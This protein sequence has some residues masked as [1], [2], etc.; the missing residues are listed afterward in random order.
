MNE[1]HPSSSPILSQA[2]I[3][4]QPK[5]LLRPQIVAKNVAVSL[6]TTSDVVT[7][8]FAQR[9]DDRPVEFSL[10]ELREKAHQEG[11]IAGL[12]EGRENGISA[13]R[14]EGLTQGYEE[15]L[16]QGQ[17]KAEELAQR[18][19]ETVREALQAREAQLLQLLKSLPEAFSR[20]FAE[21]E[22][23]M[24]A[25]VQETVLRILGQAF[26]SGD[27]A[28]MMLLQAMKEGTSRQSI[29]V[30]V[31]PDDFALLKN[32]SEDGSLKE[33]GVSC[34]A[35]KRVA[36]GGCF[37]DTRDGTLDA[38]LETQLAAFTQVLLKVRLQGRETTDKGPA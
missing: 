11:F 17:E 14:E 36:L 13:G 30:R 2:A 19:V 18:E 10:A 9:D 29:S 23:D 5:L 8:A 7:Q 24:V 16:K 37:I 6:P 15:G 1:K 32:T 34:E 25:L 26:A 33:L 38:R 4:S 28:R 27:G 21:S 22:D 20:R 3:H 31:H 35:D 12:A